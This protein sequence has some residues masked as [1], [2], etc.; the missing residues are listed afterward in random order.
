MINSNGFDIISQNDNSINVDSV[1]QRATS[2]NQTK[3]SEFLTFFNKDISFQK[4]KT[5]ETSVDQLRN[6]N[7]KKLTSKAQII[8]ESAQ[9]KKEEKVYTSFN[10]YSKK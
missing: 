7:L 6:T 1:N 2:L 4:N 10:N 8:M 9:K 3:K 5:V